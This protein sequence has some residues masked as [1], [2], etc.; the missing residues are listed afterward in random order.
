ML[1]K[2][3]TI[4]TLRELKV[5]GF[6][7]IFNPSLLCLNLEFADRWCCGGVHGL[8]LLAVP[9]KYI[10]LDITIDTDVESQ[11]VQRQTGVSEETIR[12][13]RR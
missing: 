7:N 3:P 13:T 9:E 10:I 5:L 4:I 1:P 11:P 8:T 6:S 2:T 12:T